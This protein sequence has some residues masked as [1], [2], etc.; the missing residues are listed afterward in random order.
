[1][2]S[3]NTVAGFETLFMNML[4]RPKHRFAFFS[5]TF[6]ALINYPLIINSF[7]I[8]FI[9]FQYPSLS[10]CKAKCHLL[11]VF[12]PIRSHILLSS[13]SVYYA[14]DTTFFDFTPDQNGSF[15]HH[16]WSLSSSQHAYIHQRSQPTRQTTCLST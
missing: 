14:T 1:M 8:L 2:W 16:S 13:F 11:F 3:R 12:I 6:H 4:T 15:S 10:H 5:C 9:A 7:I